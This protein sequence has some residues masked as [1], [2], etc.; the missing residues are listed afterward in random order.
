[1]AD[2]GLRSALLA[3][4]PGD[5]V[6]M[7]STPPDQAIFHSTVPARVGASV[8][9]QNVEHVQAAV[10]AAGAVDRKVSVLTSGHGLLDDI[11]GDVALNMSEFDSVSVDAQAQVATI[12]GGARWAS[13][14]AQCAPVGLAPLSGSS[15]TVGVAGY[16]TGGGIGLLSRQFGFCADHVVDVEVVT[17]AGELLTASPVEN[18]D[19]FWAIR[20]SQSSL[21][22]V[23]KLRVKL[24][25]IE[26][27]YGGNLIWPAEWAV[28]VIPQILDWAQGIPESMSVSFA[29]IDFPPIDA[30]PALMR[31]QRM[32]VARLCTTDESPASQAL[33]ADLA[34]RTKPIAN[35]LRWMSLSETPA[36]HADPDVRGNYRSWSRGLRRVGDS[37][38]QT[39]EEW[40]EG[41]YRGVGVIEFRLMGGALSR[42]PEIENCVDG[43]D[44]P[45]NCFASGDGPPGSAD[46]VDG[47][48]G[49]IAS[50]TWHDRADRLLLNFMGG[51]Q[52]NDVRSAFRT[53][54][55]NRLVGVIDEYDP[56]SVMRTVIDFPPRDESKLLC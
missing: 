39:V 11:F 38:M 31:G 15:P 6:T 27:F 17:G 13:V 24:F 5:L 56:A 45:I 40:A 12:G 51:D 29:L 32:M 26:K 2:D 18:P 25:P 35:T 14:L 37:T 34:A 30:V 7:G 42:R 8:R 52:L 47:S 49:E 19:L 10:R 36:I 3:S 23:T 53:E 22:V 28:E 33:L 9:A 1:M 20:G 55:V 41:S 21:G 48:V 43:R 54:T 16:T 46:E 4:I 50:G 44:F